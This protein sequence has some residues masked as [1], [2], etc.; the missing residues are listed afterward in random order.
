MQRNLLKYSLLFAFSFISILI[1]AGDIYS[2][3]DGVIP[4][5]FSTTKGTLS[6]KSDKGKLG[7]KSLQW[8]WTSN[9]VFS[10]SPQS[11]RTPSV[12]STGG[13]TVWIYNETPINEKITLRFY[14]FENSTTDRSCKIDFNLNFK[15]WRCLWARFRPDMNHTGYTLRNMKW[16]APKSGSG[17]ILIDYIEFVD[18]VSWERISDMQYTLKNTSDLEDFVAARN[19]IPTQFNG[20]V[21]ESQ[22][23]AFN[24]IKQRVDEWFYGTGNFEN[25]SYYKTRKN[26][27][28]TYVK[29]AT[30]KKSQIQ[31]SRQENGTVNGD[32]L[33]PMDFHNQTIDGVKVRSFRE[34]NEGFLVQLAYDAVINQ[35]QN[36]KELVL[37]IYDW[38]DDQG[39]S[40]GS[41]LGR[42]RF[43]M[44]RSSGYYYAFYMMRDLFNNEQLNRIINTN[45]WYTLFGKLY[46]TPEYKGETADMIR[47]LM[48]PKLFTVLATPDETERTIAMQ[49][50]VDY[51][52]N[53]IAIAPGY[54]GTFKPDYSGYHHRGAY[55]NAYYSEALYIGSLIYS[56]LVGTPFELSQETYNNLK[57]GLK[58]YS[59]LCADY[60]IPAGI[61]GRFP[62]QIQN[63]DK[64]L[65][66]YAYLALSTSQPDEELTSIFKN[67]WQPEQE[68][69]KSFIGRVRSDIT[70][71]N[72]MGEVEKMVEL[73][74]TTIEKKPLEEG[75]KIMPYS[76]LLVARQKDWVLRTKGFSKYIWDF[77]SSTSENL[78][79][80]YLSYG[81]IEVAKLNSTIRS[82]Q[83]DNNDWDWSHIPGTTV[84]YLSKEAINSNLLPDKH[85][86][87]SDKTFL[88]G[89][90]L[91]DNI[92][93][94]SNDM[95]DNTFDKGFYAKKS[96]FRFD[97]LYYCIGSGIKNTKDTPVHTT[98]FQNLKLSTSDALNINGNELKTNK[99]NLSHP[100]IQDNYN[101]TYIVKEG[102][103]SVRFNSS[104]ITAYIDQGKILTDG[105]YGYI[106]LLGM[107]PNESQNTIEA[108][109]NSLELL[110]NTENAHAVFQ[111][112]SNTLAVSIFNP[113]QFEGLKQLKSVN[114]PSSVVVQERGSE[115]EVAFA[116]PDMYRPSAENNDKITNAIAR[117]ESQSS[118]IEIEIIGRYVKSENDNSDVSIRYNGSNNTI[119]SYDKLIDGATY[120]VLLKSEDSSANITKEKIFKIIKNREGNTLYIENTNQNTFG[121]T[122]MNTQGKILQ[123]FEN[124]Y[125][126][127]NINLNNYPSGVYLLKFK[128][129]DKDEFFKIYQ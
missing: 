7:E 36:S 90:V 79:G 24:T 98:L 78:Y 59:F 21:T 127:C 1:Y 68:P 108:L 63:L 30:N 18:N 52:N 129:I 65:P 26:A 116:D 101:N 122:L 19:N 60:D 83:P 10:A 37:N 9:D 94:F 69:M 62:T 74:T 33:F 54:L 11:M 93:V 85:R 48:L 16:E 15:G 125:S 110:L 45:K 53:A 89:V 77:E 57:N 28:N 105:K 61:V 46:Q 82:Y 58:T 47:A 95:H 71:K 73:A 111:P 43:E 3:E 51:V 112:S 96:V 126:S 91:N 106:I 8:N 121:Y 81:Q 99:D 64:I 20:S 32:G 75:N 29:N 115:L 100:V 44:L 55:Y 2:F 109:G 13:I 104:F 5:D 42:L 103:V 114:I 4:S 107:Q 56:F 27:F 123:T 17:T 118:K 25:N 128:D 41:G 6:V 67:H 12:T 88:G 50:F 102:N 40:D 113:S 39:F 86:N 92:A 117:A 120:K 35:N 119:L 38:Y 124:I 84:K 97:N 76:G 22:R 80:R 34:I 49:K 70:F 14:E 72:T 87:F 31:L 66:A 23:S